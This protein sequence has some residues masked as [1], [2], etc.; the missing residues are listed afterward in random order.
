MRILEKQVT[1]RLFVDD[2]VTDEQLA[3][4]SEI[5]SDKDFPVIESDENTDTELTQALTKAI[6]ES[7]THL[8]AL[9]KD[10][11]MWGDFTDD[12]NSFKIHEV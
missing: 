5:L 6:T 4:M 2:S 12:E 1:V 11:D 8:G 10:S 7:D 3:Q 9:V